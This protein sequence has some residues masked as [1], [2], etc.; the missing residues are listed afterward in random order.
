MIERRQVRR[1]TPVV[2]A[3]AALLIGVDV[4][5]ALAGKPLGFPYSPLGVVSLLVYVVVGFV[6][7]WRASFAAG[8][9]AAT[10]VGF[11]DATVGPLAAWLAGP[12]SLGQAVTEPRVFAYAI[13]VGTGTAAVA[14]LVGA[15]AG[16]W[17]ERRRSVRSS[18]IVSR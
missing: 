3:A 14:G 13:T 2:L 11:L 6:G 4:V 18:G 12:G 1:V 5:G 10:I 15:A 9:L 17:L 7:A 8:L 16:S